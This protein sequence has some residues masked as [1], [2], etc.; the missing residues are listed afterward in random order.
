MN[1]F[2]LKHLEQFTVLD[3]VSKWLS[4][5][6]PFAISNYSDCDILEQE[7]YWEEHPGEAVPIM[8]PKFYWGPWRVVNGEVPRF[9]QQPDEAKAA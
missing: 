4:I 2:W 6:L 1:Q 7:K 8:P 9:I 5:Q 3:E